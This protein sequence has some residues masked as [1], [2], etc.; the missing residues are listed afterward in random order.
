[1]EAIQKIRYVPAIGIRYKF[2]F[3]KIYQK[4]NLEEY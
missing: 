1:M 4:Y 2:L 3:E